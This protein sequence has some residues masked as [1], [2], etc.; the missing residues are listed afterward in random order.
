MTNTYY[1]I[2]VNGKE[3]ERKFGLAEAKTAA[4]ENKG[5]YKINYVY[6]DIDDTEERRER[7]AKNRKNYYK[8]LE[9]K[10]K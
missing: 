8:K 4:A 7:I 5:I 2:I 9:E 6:H 3:I 10:R 1:S